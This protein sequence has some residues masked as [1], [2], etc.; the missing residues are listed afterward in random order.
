[1]ENLKILNSCT[2][3]ALDFFLLSLIHVM[4]EKVSFLG[5]IFEMEIWMDL[6]VMSSPESEND[7]FS[8]WSVCMCVSVCA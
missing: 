8:I 7:I 4:V 6:H 1:M 3:I 2:L 5:Q